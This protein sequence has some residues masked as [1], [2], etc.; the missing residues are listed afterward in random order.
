MKIYTENKSIEWEEDLS[1]AYRP[2]TLTLYNNRTV[3]YDSAWVKKSRARNLITGT[4]MSETY[5]DAVRLDGNRGSSS[6][7]TSR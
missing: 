6:T 3:T 4:T 1:A 5:H 7:R 2:T